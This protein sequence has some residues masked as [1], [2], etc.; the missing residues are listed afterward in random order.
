MKK[1]EMDRRGFLKTCL[2][3]AAAVSAAA[4]SGF[5]MNQSPAYDAKGLPRRVFGKTG[6]RLPIIGF[7]SGSRFC[8]V[9]DPEKNAAILTY[10]LDNGFYWWDSSADYKNDKVISEELLGLVLKDRRKEVFLST[11]ANERN[12]DGAMRELEVS[13][14]RLQTDH[15]DL[16]QIHSVNDLADVETIGAKEGMLKALLKAKEEKLTRFIGYSGHQ[17]GGAMTAMVQRYD[18]DAMLIALNHQAGGKEEMEKGAMPE[19]AKKNMGIIAMKVIRPRETVKTLTPEDLI[20]YALTIPYVS[21][22]VIGMDS[23][24]VVK[25]NRDLLLNFKPLNSAEMERIKADL[26]P[27]YEN[28]ALPWMHPS[29]RDGHFA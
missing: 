26:R 9:K 12:Y 5:S 6:V 28:K 24:E 3:S 10:A 16:W 25:E 11:K 19:A 21:T 22:A 8:A 20:R 7:G 2:A 23:I 15:L 18:F 14:K 1:R 27:F 29:Y 4:R 13:L 17:S